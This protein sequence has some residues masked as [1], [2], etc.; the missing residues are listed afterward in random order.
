MS[1]FRLIEYFNDE[2]VT[3]LK[4]CIILPPRYEYVL[5]HPNIGNSTTGTSFENRYLISKF[6]LLHLYDIILFF[7]QFQ[8][9]QIKSILYQL[10][11]HILIFDRVMQAYPILGYG[12]KINNLF[13]IIAHTKLHGV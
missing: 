1:T 3:M 8:L 11:L 7:I 6:P 13:I 2:Y 9:R 4:W 10:S 12:L 5:K